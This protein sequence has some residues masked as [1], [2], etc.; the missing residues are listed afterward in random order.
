[1]SRQ[2]EG[3]ASRYLRMELRTSPHAERGLSVDVIMRN[4]VYALAPLAV[5]AVY[6]FGLS[7]A[8]LLAVT[9]GS[10]LLTE[11]AVTR[12]QGTQSTLGDWSAA[13]TG[14]L[15]GLTLPPAFPLWMAALGG[16]VS[17][18]LGKSLFGGLGYNVFNPALVGRAFLQAAFPVAI[19]TWSAPLQAGRFT[20]TFSATLG[21]PFLRP[22]YDA[23]TGATPLAA[24]KFDHRLTDSVDLLLGGVSGSAGETSALLIALGGLYLAL[25]GMLDWRIPAGVLGTVAA[26][27]GLLHW[28]HPAYPPAGFMLLSGGL[29]L[30]A[31]YMAT[32][33][34]TS[35][36]TPLGV[37]LFAIFIGAVTVVIRIWGGL[38]EGVMYA[39][40][41]GN[42][43]TPLI[44]LVTQPR[45]YGAKGRS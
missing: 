43:L 41:L 42:A 35:P 10:A 16:I 29:M 17:I 20:A 3:R 36:V 6:A 45:I 30:G 21:W 22:V 4:V 12:F 31:V 32:D 33:M 28:L 37:W 24:L 7:A 8:L 9:T 26:L 18:A 39:I 5:M 34:V 40:L 44:N 14:L 15:L 38:P 11:Y 1:M 19:T 25:R 23:A 13:I 2:P 27:A